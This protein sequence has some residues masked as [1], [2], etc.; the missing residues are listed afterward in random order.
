MFQVIYIPIIFQWYKELFN[1]MSFDPCNRPLKIW[2]SIKI[3]T[4]KLGIHLGMWRFIPSHSPT[5]PGT[6]NVI[7]RLHSWLAPSQT[8]ALVPKKTYVNLG[9]NQPQP[10]TKFFSFVKMEW[11]ASINYTYKKLYEVQEFVGFDVE[12]FNQLQLDKRGT[13]GS[14]RVC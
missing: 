1:P 2:E 11:N 10:N 5:F 6:W 3:S 14:K 13:I 9:R 8:L 12:S 7:P 4:P